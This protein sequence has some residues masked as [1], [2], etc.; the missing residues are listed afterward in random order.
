MKMQCPNCGAD[1]KPGANLRLNCG[2]YINSDDDNETQ[3]KLLVILLM[4]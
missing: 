2:Y 4:K 3:M 1:I